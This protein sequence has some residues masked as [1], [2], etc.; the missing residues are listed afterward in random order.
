MFTRM[1]I[2]T[3]V[4]FSTVLAA[5]SPAAE[6][7][8]QPTTSPFQA[9]YL[10]QHPGQLS[11]DDLQAHPE[12]AVTENFDEFKQHALTKI[13][14]WIDRNAVSLVDNQWLRDTPQKNY[15]VVLVGESNE[16]CAFKESLRVSDIEGPQADCS[17][18]APGFSV[19]MLREDTGS[20]VSAFM[21][22]YSQTPT[23][24]NILD[25]TNALLEGKIK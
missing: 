14:L 2:I 19:W 10:V 23:V 16:L 15:P 17:A 11:L 20:S 9:V 6:P 3:F 22:G 5:C 24:Q 25:I 1:T 13:A 12:V 7:A 4:L 8:T 18:E 21:K